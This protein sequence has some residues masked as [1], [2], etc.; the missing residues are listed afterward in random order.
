MSGENGAGDGNRT[1]TTSLE[2]WDS[3]IELH[4]RLNDGCYFNI[5]HRHLS[6]VILNFFIYFFNIY[7]SSVFS[8]GMLMQLQQFDAI[9]FILHLSA[10]GQPMHFLPLF[11]VLYIYN[12]ERTT[13]TA[14]IIIII[15]SSIKPPLI[16][17]LQLPF[18]LF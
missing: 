3:T 10:Y 15:M 16:I 5:Y 18:S 14:T 6:I 13:I 7:I 4:P 1:H 9:L 17:L 11:F 2:G 12:P 8:S